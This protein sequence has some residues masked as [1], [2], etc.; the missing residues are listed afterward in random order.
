MLDPTLSPVIGYLI[1]RERAYTATSNNTTTITF[2]ETAI[3][4]ARLQYSKRWLGFR[5]NIG[6][7]GVNC[8]ETF[9]MSN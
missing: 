8:E 1:Y 3:P 9:F 2:C 4:Q 7:F 5:T 6:V